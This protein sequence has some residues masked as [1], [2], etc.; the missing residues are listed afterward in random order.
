M[1]LISRLEAAESGSRELDGDIFQLTG[2]GAW[3]AACS[4]A[5]QP[6]GA[7]EATVVREARDYAPHYTTSLDAAVTLMPERDGSNKAGFLQAAMHQ[8]CIGDI[9]DAR[10]ALVVCIKALKARQ[11]MGNE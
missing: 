10:L 11:E 8:T 3:E 2:G 5:S 1:T 9:L 6:C 7:P 4:R